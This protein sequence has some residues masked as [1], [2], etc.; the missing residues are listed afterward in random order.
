MGT[1]D[2]EGALESCNSRGMVVVGVASFGETP[3]EAPYRMLSQ[4]QKGQSLLVFVA[5]AHATLPG[6]P[7]KRSPIILIIM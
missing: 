7:R 6:G 2:A 4:R 3:K 1:G 5:W